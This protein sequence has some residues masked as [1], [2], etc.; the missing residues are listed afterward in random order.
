MDG[1][2]GDR[3]CTNEQCRFADTAECVEGNDINECPYL[4]VWDASASEDADETTSPGPSAQQ[5]GDEPVSLGGEEHLSVTEASSLLKAR[6]APIIAFLGTAGAGKTSL[7][8]EVYDAFQYKTYKSLAF[9]GSRTLIAFERIC[10]KI[11]AAS[12]AP[13]PTQDRSEILDDPF[14]FH[15]TIHVDNTEHLTDILL[16]DRSG[17]TYRAIADTPA[18]A[19]KCLELRRAAT[20][21]ILVDGA[22]LC[23]PVQRASALTECNQALQTLTMSGILA[24]DVSVNLVMTK[25]DLVDTHEN[26]ARAHRDF[27]SLRDRSLTRYGDSVARVNSF[28]IAACP[29]NDKHPKGYGVEALI[30]NW[31]TTGPLQGIYSNPILVGERA[32]SRAPSSLE[33]L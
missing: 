22:R 21:N 32:M 26:K 11:R 20:L 29:Q 13:E 17:E 10:Q 28:K 23:D 30:K 31:A 24:Q 18:V 14:F 19:A 8:A 15:L 4:E 1:A 6:D 3:V 12:K 16:A 2:A 9:A 33:M 27:E 5:S 7:I 25:L